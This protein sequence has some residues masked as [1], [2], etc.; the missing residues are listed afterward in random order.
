M[1]RKCHVRFGGGP[2][3]KGSHE[4]LAGGLPDYPPMPGRSRRTFEF[5]RVTFAS[6]T[7][8]VTDVGGIQRVSLGAPDWAPMT[9]DDL[10]QLLGG[11]TARS[12][13]AYPDEV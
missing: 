4:Y 13:M 8:R 9:P 3:E 10:A 7:P 2:T 12:L 11:E 6:W 5:D 1:M